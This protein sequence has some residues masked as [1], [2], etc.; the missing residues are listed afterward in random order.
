LVS[1][2]EFSLRYSDLLTGSYDCVDRIVLNAF[3]PL[4]HNPGGFRV[5]WRRW[6]DD[7]DAELD[8][9]HLMRL[10]GRF[11]RRV[12]AWGAANA[13]PVIFCKAG[14][15]KH[16][17]AEEYLAT[18]EV[19]TGVF[20]VLAA[21]APATVWKVQRSAAGRI[22]NIERRREHVNH[23]S[24]HIID[25]EWG[26]VTIKMSGHPPFGAQIILNGHEYVARQATA[27]GIAFSKAGNCFTGIADPAGLARIADALSQD[28]TV[29]RLSQVCR[30]WIYTACLCFGLDLDEQQRSGFAYG[31]AVYQ[32]EYSRNLIFAD[33]ARMQQLFDAVV[34]RT[35]SRLDVPK[36]RTIFGAA[37]RPCPTRKRSSTIEAAIETPTYDLTVFKLHFG[38]LTGKAYTK[39]ERV[40]RFEAIAHNTAQL[41]C[42]RM[43]E[44]FPEIVTQLAGIADRF[45]TALDCVDTGFLADDILDQLPTGTQLGATRIGGVDLNNKRMRDALSAVLALAPAPHGFTVSEFAAKVHAMTGTSG[46]EYSV[47]Q[48]AYDLRKLRGKRLVDKPGRTRRYHI[49]PQAARTIAAMLTLR[50]QVIAPI[51]AAVRS[52]RMGRKPAHWTRVDRDYEQIRI[53]MQTLFTDLALE[54]P[55][56]A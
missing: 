50:D 41:R 3:F 34:D 2:D 9:T 47:R 45:A 51:L 15:R 29:G 26:H 12:K 10:A 54:T 30:R 25:P 44:K 5:W 46:I 55:S 37:R 18:H 14:E 6:H 56:A 36:I 31:F 38:R 20:L 4:G 49:P 1:S 52:P 28:A 11:A 13:V 40:L 35:R 19:D 39:G 8:N 22:V 7:S 33:G 43:I 21:K 24:F 42:G 16:R 27:A 23:Y 32:L 48:A 53:D 17:I